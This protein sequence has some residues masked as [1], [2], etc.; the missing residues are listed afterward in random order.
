LGTGGPQE[1]Q[2]EL[3]HLDFQSPDPQLRAREP[4]LR[5]QCRAADRLHAGQQLGR[6]IGPGQKLSAPRSSPCRRSSSVQLLTQ[7]KAIQSG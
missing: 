1:L 4:C 7:G 6:R 5:L 3:N 2:R